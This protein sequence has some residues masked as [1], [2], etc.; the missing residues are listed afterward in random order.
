MKKFFGLFAVLFI[1]SILPVNAD[2][3]NYRIKQEG[4]KMVIVPYS[5]SNYY[6]IPQN[7]KINT[8]VSTPKIPYY[9]KKLPKGVNK[10][11]YV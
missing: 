4:S 9:Q 3:L 10:S 11:R 8:E 1:I 5:S 7:H 2:T 6:E